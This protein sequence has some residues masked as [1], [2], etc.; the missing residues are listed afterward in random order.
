MMNRNTLIHL[1]LRYQGNWGK[2]HDALLR[3]ESVE[4]TE[5][6]V[7]A[8][9]I[10]DEAY[11]SSLLRLS[12]PPWVLFYEGD[13]SLLTRRMISVVGSRKMTLY[14]KQVTDIAV[15]ILKK[16]FVIVSGLA[17]G[18]DGEAHRRAI[19]GGKT[20]GIIGHGLDVTYP[21]SNKDIYAVMRKTSLILSEY[22]HGTPIRKQ[23]FPFRNR[24]IAALGE[25]LVVTEA[26]FQ[27]GTLHTVNAALALGKDIYCFPYPFD[28]KEGSLCL[29]LMKEGAGILA[30]R[31]DIAQLRD[32]SG[33]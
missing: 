6:P 12:E 14:G 33:S 8:I 23:Y 2:I 1:S 24:I 30:T 9:T 5:L 16:D 3:E 18:V 19:C 15:D 27:S 29:E 22:P 4:T 21:S 20:I 28:N 32:V 7:Q 17:K 10:F 11:P 25:K 31:E 13:I 26:A